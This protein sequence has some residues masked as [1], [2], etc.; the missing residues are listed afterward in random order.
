M[1][2]NKL[3]C[4]LLVSATAFAQTNNKKEILSLFEKA[5][6]VYES[7][8]FFQIE[9]KCSIYTSY[10]ATVPKEQYTGLI[11][12]KSNEYYSKIGMIEMVSLKDFQIVID[13]GLKKISVSEMENANSMEK[14]YDLTGFCQNFNSFVLTSQNNSWVCTLTAPKVAFA[15]YGKMI[16]YID[17]STNR[18]TKQVVYLLT[19]MKYK[20]AKGKTKEAY[21]KM[22]T[23]FISF[24]SDISKHQ[25]KFSSSQYITKSKGEF[26]VSKN[27]TGYKL[28]D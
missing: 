11:L 7:N 27:Y 2:I 15:P 1:G 28:I 25:Y 24:K 21:P 9:T 10:N 19:S 13:N 14:A 17:K 22:V 20:D 26:S 12:K 5:K 8:N 3:L 16:V 23:E 18:I 4:C 6:K